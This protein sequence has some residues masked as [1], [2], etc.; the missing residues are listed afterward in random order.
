MKKTLGGVLVALPF[1]AI[2]VAAAIASGAMWWML[3]IPLG[4]TALFVGLIWLGVV[5]MLDD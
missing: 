5:L 1:V 3:L 2:F 4:I